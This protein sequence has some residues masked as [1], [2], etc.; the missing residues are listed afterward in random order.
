[1]CTLLEVLCRQLFCA[2]VPQTYLQ[3]C[4]STWFA[5]LAFGSN[6]GRDGSAHGGNNYLLQQRLSHSNSLTALP[7]IGPNGQP[8]AVMVLASKGPGDSLG[9]SS[10]H[11][12][13]NGNGKHPTWRAHV[14][15]RGEV[16]GGVLGGVLC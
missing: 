12:Q 7:T 3:V 1:M 9:L 8:Q 11:P 2:P 16:R 14:R 15:A 4:T 13:T 10:L 6:Q 5:G